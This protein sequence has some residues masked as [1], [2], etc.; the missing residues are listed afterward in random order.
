MQDDDVLFGLLQERL[1]QSHYQSRV[2][3]IKDCD[4]RLIGIGDFV[5]VCTKSKAGTHGMVTEI[6]QNQVHV[7]LCHYV[8]S[9]ANWTD[10]MR[11]HIRPKNLRIIRKNA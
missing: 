1:R 8:A 11:T 5:E 4:G 9:D 10:P 3:C 7:A 6:E 2:N